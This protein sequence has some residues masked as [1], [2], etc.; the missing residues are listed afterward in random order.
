MIFVRFVDGTGAVVSVVSAFLFLDAMF[1]ELNSSSAVLPAAVSM[2]VMSEKKPSRSSML[3]IFRGGNVGGVLVFKLMNEILTVNEGNNMERIWY[4]EFLLP[5][6]FCKY[7]STR[8][9]KAPSTNPLYSLVSASSS[10][11]GGDGG[12]ALN[13]TKALPCA[14]IAVMAIALATLAM[15]ALTGVPL[16]S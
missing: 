12:P 4:K 13:P 1:T 15:V 7:F 2:E 6:M 14:P 11:S 8:V 3:G 10:V 9:T 5:H 16:A